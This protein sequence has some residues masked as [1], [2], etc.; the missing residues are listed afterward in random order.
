MQA[1]HYQQYE[2]NQEEGN[3]GEGEGEDEGE[4]QDEDDQEIE[5]SEEQFAE[6]AQNYHLLPP[7]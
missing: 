7:E 6:L 1:Q 3:E 2:S 5:I 4:G